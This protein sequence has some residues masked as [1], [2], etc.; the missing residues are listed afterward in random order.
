[1][2]KEYTVVFLETNKSLFV[3]KH[4][5]TAVWNGVFCVSYEDYF[6]DMR[7]Y[8]WTA[9]DQVYSEQYPLVLS[10]IYDEQIVVYGEVC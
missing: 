3:N 7:E 5:G 4:T 1:M 6:Q 2:S 9:D 10:S 8:T